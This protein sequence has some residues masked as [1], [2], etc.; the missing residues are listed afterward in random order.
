MYEHICT[1][2]SKKNPNYKGENV[3]GYSMMPIVSVPYGS[4]TPLVHFP[5]NKLVLLV[6]NNELDLSRVVSTLIEFIDLQ[7]TM[8]TWCV[9]A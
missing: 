8:F 2:T 7:P 9:S 5:L 4:L 3:F 6:I 1:D